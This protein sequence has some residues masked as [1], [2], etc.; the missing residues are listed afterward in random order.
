MSDPPFAGVATLGK[1]SD[2]H[3]SK[4]AATEQLT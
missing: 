1:I 4:I 3:K 2:L